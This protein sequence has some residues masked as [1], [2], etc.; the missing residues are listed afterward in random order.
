MKQI[1]LLLLVLL[2]LAGCSTNQEADPAPELPEMEMPQEM[3]GDFDFLVRY[4]YGENTKNEINTYHDTVVKDLIANGT[5]TAN[6]TLTGE[7]MSSIYDKMKEIGMMRPMK[8]VPDKVNCSA[9][10]HQEDH[11]Q[12]TANGATV[13]LTW[14]D[15]PCEL[16][17]DAGRLLALR[18]FVADIIASKEA[19]QAL[20]EAEGGYE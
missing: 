6:I 12:I 20:P 3:P 16:T 2:M 15:E 10:P 8:L 11:W 1:G 7:E 9:V 5:A 13:N 14:S 4:G 17:E 18:N 19:Y